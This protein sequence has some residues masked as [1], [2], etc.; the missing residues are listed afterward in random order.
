[1]ELGSD[2]ELNL[3]GLS[4]KNDSIYQYLQEYDTIF[5][6]SGRTAARVLNSK[7]KIG[8]ILL[9]DYICESVIQVY[10]DKFKIRYYHINRD[11]SID[12]DDF[13]NKMDD[14]VTIVYIMHYFGMIQENEILDAIVSEKN[15]YGFE[16][17]EDTTH[18]IFTK[19]RTIGDYCV[20]S[21][22]KW[23]P[24]TDGGVL[25]SYQ[26]LKDIYVQ[27]IPVKEPLERLTAM[28]LKKLYIDGKLDCNDLYREIFIR[29][30]EKL[31][32]QDRVYQISDISRSL[33]KYFSVSDL[34]SKRIKNYGIVYETLCCK[35]MNVLPKCKEMVPLV[36]PV[37]IE[38]RDKFRNYLINNH[39]YCAV[40]WPLEEPELYFNEETVYVSKHI[41]SLPIDQRY[42]RK[43]MDYLCTLV[44]EYVS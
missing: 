25:Y 41:I 4:V 8:T 6:D 23:F 2:F 19:S 9:P 3:S 35:S 36:C 22:R 24:V 38:D 1:M 28:L 15:K 11:F 42:D 7:L 32:Q 21:L 40:H 33:L 39:V 37:Y 20:C 44:K 30:E 29:E 34:I 10:R 5:F 18:S 26:G 17:I 13:E 27:D 14:S 16:I 12:F 43:H 31:D